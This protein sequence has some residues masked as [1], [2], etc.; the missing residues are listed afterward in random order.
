MHSHPRLPQQPRIHLWSAAWD[1]PQL[2]KAALTVHVQRRLSTTC[3][4]E[5]HF[6]NTNLHGVV[7]CRCGSRELACAKQGNALLSDMQEVNRGDVASRSMAGLK[8]LLA[9]QSEGL[10]AGCTRACFDKRH[11]MNTIQCLFMCCAR[12]CIAC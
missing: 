4:H 8:L 6:R 12:E 11:P 5:R 2:P 9:R 7:A 10:R 1:D 3:F